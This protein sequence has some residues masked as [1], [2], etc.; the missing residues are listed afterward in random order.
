M[1]G[2][3]EK[4]IDHRPEWKVWLKESWLHIPRVGLLSESFIIHALMLGLM[5]LE[6]WKKK[7]FT[8]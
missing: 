3:V 4:S 5:E 8:M 1:E 2:C 7:I 6:K